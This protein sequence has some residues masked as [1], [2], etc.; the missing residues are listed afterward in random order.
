MRSKEELVRALYSATD[1]EHNFFFLQFDPYAKSRR[2]KG[3]EDIQSNRCSTCP[4]FEQG[5]IFQAQKTT[6]DSQK[7]PLFKDSC[8]GF[9]QRRKIATLRVAGQL[10]TAT[11]FFL[12]KESGCGLNI[13]EF[14]PEDNL[15]VQ[16]KVEELV[17]T[18]EVD[19]GNKKPTNPDKKTVFKLVYNPFSHSPIFEQLIG[20][21]P[22]FTTAS[23]T[24]TEIQQNF[25]GNCPLN[26]LRQ[27]RI[28]EENCT[29]FNG[30]P[31]RPDIL[32]T[33]TCSTLKPNWLLS[34]LLSARLTVQGEHTEIPANIAKETVCRTYQEPLPPIPFARK[35]KIFL[36]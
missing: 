2:I 21:L 7:K 9:A 16:S 22:I 15:P 29:D 20:P 27:K 5:T 11:A 6:K 8:T 26:C 23:H 10:D 13:E 25:C 32:E 4:L 19:K 12:R 24:N 34:Y 1:R 30:L 36:N 17:V 33:A 31:I 18:C 14:I 28:K 35:R 3:T